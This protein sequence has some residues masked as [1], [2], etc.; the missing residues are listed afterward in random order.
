MEG[1]HF[2][3]VPVEIPGSRHSSGRRVR[4]EPLNKLLDLA[5]L[6]CLTSQEMDAPERFC[7]TLAFAQFAGSRF[8]WSNKLE[9]GPAICDSE[10]RLAVLKII[11]VP[12]AM[13]GIVPPQHRVVVVYSN[14]SQR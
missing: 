14:L 2:P 12:R 6:E 3:L 8:R 11:A 4:A 5:T 1:I 10:F 13:L 9:A 7:P